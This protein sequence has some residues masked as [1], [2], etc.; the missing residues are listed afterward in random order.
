MAGNPT[1]PEESDVVRGKAARLTALVAAGQLAAGNIYTGRFGEVSGL[2]AKIKWG[3]AFTSKPIALRGWMKYTPATINKAKA[4]YL[5][6]KG[7]PD[8]CSIKMYLTDWTSQFNIDTSN[9]VFLQEDDASIIASGALYS[10][11]SNSGYVQFTIPFEYRD[12]ERIPSYIVVMASSCRY[13][14]YFT[15]G[16]GSTLLIDEFE[17]IYDPSELTE[18]QRQLVRYRN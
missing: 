4:P 8:W 16:E 1:T 11:T 5:D 10:Q 7:Q 13:A 3:Y 15:G 14:D 2:G 12:L 17:L 6:L 9:K 18:A